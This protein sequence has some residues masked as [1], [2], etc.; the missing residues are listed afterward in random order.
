MAASAEKVFGRQLPNG[1]IVH[2]IDNNKRNNSREN[3]VMSMLYQITL[4]AVIWI[5]HGKKGE[6]RGT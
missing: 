4:E 1:V 6:W 5:H 2:H 3:L